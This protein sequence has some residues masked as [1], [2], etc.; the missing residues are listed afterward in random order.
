MAVP[1]L[2]FMAYERHRGRNSFW[3]GGRE[4]IDLTAPL[5]AFLSVA[6]QTLASRREEIDIADGS[7]TLYAAAKSPARKYWFY[8][9]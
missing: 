7:L 3:T 1:A 8:F 4:V 2:Y 6:C 9:A 5:G